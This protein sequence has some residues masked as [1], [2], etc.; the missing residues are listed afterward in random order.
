MPTE[1]PSAPLTSSTDQVMEHLQAIC[2][3]S[4]F[5]PSKRSQEFLRYVV[6]EALHGRADLI[7]ERNI[8]HEVFSKGD[9]FEPG[10]YSLVRVKA[11]EVRKRLADYY[12]SASEE[13]VRIELPVGSYAPRIHFSGKTAVPDPFPAEPAITAAE[14]KTG[15]SSRRRFLLAAGGTVT[16]AVV[17]ACTWPLL[18]PKP[19]LDLLWRPVLATR[20]PL[21]IFLPVLHETDDDLTDLVGIGPVV[22]LRQAADFF[23]EHHHPYN[24][25]F[26]ADLTFSDLREQPSLLLGG[27]TA[28]WTRRILSNL[29][30]VPFASGDVQ[31][32]RSFVDTQ[33]KKVWTAI[34]RTQT[35]Y[36][37]TDYGV[38][39]RLFDSISGQIVFLAV[40]TW[41]FGTEG[42]A[43]L[44]FQPD[45]FS[46]L[47][48]QAPKNWESKNFQAV[49]RVSVIG[50]T[51]SPPQIVASH[52]W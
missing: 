36:A 46:A 35:P 30:Y 52:F 24:L 42:A 45:H 11:G 32:E 49:V 10:E 51:S 6:M 50:N 19:A 8:A 31:V 15:K 13:A 12:K 2:K 47:M 48:Q 40:G 22:A 4:A 33:T 44:L 5:L 26:G 29:R 23:T 39:C 28:D 14:D 38:L 41:T 16:A 20:Q 7:K 34:R 1:T 37:D 9:D 43:S 21:L 27:Y 18:R 3:S 17:A 25:R